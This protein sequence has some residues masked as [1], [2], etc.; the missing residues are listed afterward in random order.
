MNEVTR[1]RLIGIL[2]FSFVF[3][4]SSWAQTTSLR[5]LIDLSGTWNFQLDPQE[6]GEQEM[7][8]KTERLCGNVYE[9]LRRL[10]TD[11]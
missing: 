1:H 4:Y 9:P 10:E 6:K 11:R 8:S 7:F 5:K 3:S 2:L